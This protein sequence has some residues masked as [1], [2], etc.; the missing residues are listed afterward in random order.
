MFG[1]PLLHFSSLSHQAIVS[2]Y[3]ADD[4]L[5]VENAKIAFLR[6]VFK[7]PTFGSAFFE[8]KVNIVECIKTRERTEKNLVKEVHSIKLIT[9]VA[10]HSL[11]RKP[12]RNL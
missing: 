6:Y 2:H 9:I 1:L 7:W 11:T 8:V 5:T 4:G 10:S 3:N 12:E